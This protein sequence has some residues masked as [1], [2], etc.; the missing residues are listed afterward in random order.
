MIKSLS[1][2]GK[3]LYY[4]SKVKGWSL[5]W[6]MKDQVDVNMMNGHFAHMGIQT[7]F[8]CILCS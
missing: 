7:I 2:I 3:S 8:I 5:V 4:E 6:I 1:L